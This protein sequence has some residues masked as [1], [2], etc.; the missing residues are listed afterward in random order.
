V[1][2]ITALGGAILKALV[3]IRAG[4]LIASFAFIQIAV[5]AGN[6]AEA[7]DQPLKSV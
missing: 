4:I 5:L 3:A 1:D 2:P 7:V 6:E